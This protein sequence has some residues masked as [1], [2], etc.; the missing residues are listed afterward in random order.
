MLP[1][2]EKY[3]FDRVWIERSLSIAQYQLHELG[4]FGDKNR[5]RNA[6]LLDII[7]KGGK[8]GSYRAV[9]LG[10]RII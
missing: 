8:S 3:K 6:S 1:E 9:T 10:R 2:L 5:F 4:Y 7:M